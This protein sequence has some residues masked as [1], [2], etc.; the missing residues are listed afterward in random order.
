MHFLGRVWMLGAGLS[1][2]CSAAHITQDRLVSLSSEN[3]DGTTKVELITKGLGQVDFFKLDPA[4]NATTFDS[5]YFDA[6][7]PLTNETVIFNFEIQSPTN[8]ANVSEPLYRVSLYGSFANGTA[9]SYEV[10]A[11]NV[12]I[13]ENDENGTKVAYFGG[14]D[15]S[16]S[17]TSLLKPRPVYT[18]TINST[19]VGI[20]GT[21]ILQGNLAAPHYSC[22]IDAAG[23]DQQTAPGLDGLMRYPTLTPLFLSIFAIRQCL[24]KDMAIMTKPGLIVLLRHRC[25]PRFGVTLA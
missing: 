7:N 14:N 11:E 24:L 25:R 17:G 19:E 10:E 2:C 12:N 23:V 6:M 8:S 21:L 5:W 13:T 9:Y 16:W 18:V 3:Y 22:G 1:A 4:P 15:F 20:S